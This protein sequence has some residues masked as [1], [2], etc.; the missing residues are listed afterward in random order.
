MQ[1][2]NHLLQQLQVHKLGI[3]ILVETKISGEM[4]KSVCESLTFSQIVDPIGFKEGLWLLWD[5][6]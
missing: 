5:D 6:A 2:R 4:A 1:F 3:V